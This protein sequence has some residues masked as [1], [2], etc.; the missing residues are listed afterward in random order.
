MA[1]DYTCWDCGYY[2]GRHELTCPKKGYLMP[3]A[4]KAPAAPEPVRVECPCGIHREDCDYHRPAP[5][6]PYEYGAY[7]FLSRWAEVLG[8]QRAVGE[9]DD[10]L[11]ARL[12]SLLKVQP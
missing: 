6:K 2:G 10:T 8:T 3:S 9:S 4:P 11:R 5:P 1:K 7:D 12:R